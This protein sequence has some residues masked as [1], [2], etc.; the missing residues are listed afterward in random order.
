MTNVLAMEMALD[1]FSESKK[2]A[3]SGLRPM[4]YSTEEQ[5]HPMGLNGGNGMWQQN[6]DQVFDKSGQ[7]HATWS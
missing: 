3:L 4:H 2:G 7:A 6:H 5:S 1:H